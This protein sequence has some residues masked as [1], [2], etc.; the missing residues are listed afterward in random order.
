MLSFGQLM[1][2]IKVYDAVHLAVKIKAAESGRTQESLASDMI[3]YVLDLIESGKLPIQK[4]D[5]SDKRRFS[6]K[7]AKQ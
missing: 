2:V 6:R 1:K 3:R 4:L 7:E 5:E